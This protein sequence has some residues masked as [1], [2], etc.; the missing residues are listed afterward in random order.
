[1]PLTSLNFGGIRFVKGPKL[2]YRL[3]WG[4]SPVI[5]P[6]V[7]RLGFGCVLLDLQQ[8]KWNH[9]FIDFE[10]LSFVKE[11]P[12]SVGI[13][14][15]HSLFPCHHQCTLITTQTCYSLHILSLIPS[16]CKNDLSLGLVMMWWPPLLL[17]IHTSLFQSKLGDQ[18]ISFIAT[19]CLQL[20][21]L[22]INVV[23]SPFTLS[24][25]RLL[26]LYLQWLDILFIFKV[27]PNLLLLLLHMKEHLLLL[28]I[29]H[30]KFV[31]VTRPDWV[32]EGRLH[33]FLDN[34]QQLEL[35][36]RLKL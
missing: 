18:M 20:P 29:L 24:Y 17:W 6:E 25:Y 27:Y 15:L 14:E 13:L 26:H 32:G 7:K 16:L 9:K 8:F 21:L 31:D 5:K 10:H 19:W 2:F 22:L 23:A 36:L 3:A 35:L 33:F 1:M 12:F 4:P 11:F 30:F 28:W 34:A